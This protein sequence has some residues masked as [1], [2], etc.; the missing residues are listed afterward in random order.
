M[1]TSELFA[2]WIK[3]LKRPCKKQDVFNG[4]GGWHTTGIQY[5][6]NERCL[7][8]GSRGR[9]CL[10]FGTPHSM[11]CLYKMF[12][13]W[14]YKRSETT[15]DCMSGPE[16]VP[17]CQAYLDKLAH[18]RQTAGM[19]RMKRRLMT[20]DYPATVY[21]HAIQM[22]NKL[23]LTPE[24][25]IYCK[26][27]CCTLSDKAFNFYLTKNEMKEKPK[28]KELFFKYR[29][30]MLPKA[31]MAKIFNWASP[32]SLVRELFLV[33]EEDVLV[34]VVNPDEKISG[35]AIS[36]VKCRNELKGDVNAKG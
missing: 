5:R 31:D 28:Y 7:C 24:K 3:W 32:R 12:R 36:I 27:L 9:E 20:M 1:T 8:M 11:E 23:L 35:L 33:T 29:A 6:I 34:H 19:K 2:E 21:A 18:K 30:Q 14:Y 13:S 22:V 10:F 26:S 15:E 25:D 17:V 16:F 4:Q